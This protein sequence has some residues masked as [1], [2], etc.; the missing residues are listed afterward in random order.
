MRKIVFN[1]ETIQSI[2]EYATTHTLIESCNRFTLKPDTMKRVAKENDIKFVRTRKPASTSVSEEI[3]NAICSL[4][5]NTNAPINAIRDEIGVRISTV[6]NV[7]NE[8]YTE[9]Y[10]NE[11]RAK[12]YRLSKLGEKNPMFG[13]YGVEHSKFKGIIEDGNGYLMCLKPD[14]YTGRK[15]SNYVFLHSIVVCEALGLTEI[16]KGFVVHHIDLNPKNNDIS[17]LALMSVAAHGK[18]H[19]ILRKVQRSEKIRREES[20]ETL[21]NG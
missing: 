21:D 20:P 17:N 3:I 16:P 4:Y 15:G 1:E 14:W 18:L 7:I 19:N 8:H 5:E 11:R 10:R 13:K 9:E 6:Y 2:R 12:L